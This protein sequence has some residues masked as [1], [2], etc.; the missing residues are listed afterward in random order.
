MTWAFIVL[1][2]CATF[3]HVGYLRRC[4]AMIAKYYPEVHVYL[5]DDHSPISPRILNLPSA[6]LESISVHETE[7]QR[8]G[9]VNPYLFAMSPECKHERLVFIHDTVFVKPGLSEHVTGTKLVSVL[10]VSKTFLF[11]HTF[12]DENVPI[13]ETLTVEGKTIKS[14]LE[15]VRTQSPEMFFVTFG[16]MTIF[17]RAF[18][19]GVEKISNLRECAGMFKKRVHRCLWERVL[20]VII[21]SLL[22]GEPSNVPVI[23][24]DIQEHPSAFY[25]KDPTVDYCAPLVKCWQGR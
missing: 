5:L 14:V 6:T 2:Y 4:L 24:G 15:N 19:R 10:W 16:G 13:L 3:E 21:T 23:C 1:T 20:S 18:A 22:G 11:S 7:F 9:E 17:T 25:N 12:E 8:A